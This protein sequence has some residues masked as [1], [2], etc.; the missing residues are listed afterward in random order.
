MNTLSSL[1]RTFLNDPEGYMTTLLRRAE[2]LFDQGYRAEAASVPHVFVVTRKK[3]PA[4]TP[5]DGRYLV[6]AVQVTCTCPFFTRQAAEPLCHDG[7]PVPCKHL[8]GLQ[9]LVRLTAEERKAT[10]DLYA[11]YRLASHWMGVMAERHRTSIEFR[12]DSVSASSMKGV[13]L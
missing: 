3:R 13:G 4:D 8:L 11:Y 7:T 2:R 12:R 9:T 5:E 10:R 1:Q 6:H